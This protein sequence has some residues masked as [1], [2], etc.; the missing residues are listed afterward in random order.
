MIAYVF[1]L[2]EEIREY[3]IFSEK[4][5]LEYGYLLQIF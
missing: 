3:V 4:G 2:G 5:K 1:M